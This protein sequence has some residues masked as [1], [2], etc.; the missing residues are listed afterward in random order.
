MASCKFCGKQEPVLYCVCA[1]CM[2]KLGHQWISVKERLPEP[3]ERVLVYRPDM[4]RRTLGLYLYNGVG[5]VNERNLM[6]PTGC[7]CQ[8]RRRISKLEIIRVS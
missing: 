5:L 1:G 3:N 8:A 6:F 7:R 2:G 4:K